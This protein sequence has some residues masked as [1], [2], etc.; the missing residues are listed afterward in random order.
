MIAAQVEAQIPSLRRYARALTGDATAGDDLVQ[1]CMER[2]LSRLH[3]LRPDS[4]LRA[5]L[6]T[7]MRNIWRN[8]LQ[9]RAARPPLHALDDQAEPS[10]AGDQLDRL[11]LRDM[12]AA[13][14]ALP[15]EQREVVLLVALEGLR[16][17]EVA[18]IAGVPIGTVMSR[19]K[20][21]RD[22]LAQL[23]GDSPPLRRVK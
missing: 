14:L 8:E 10:V 6:F 19:L 15:D 18:A 12:Q 21:G 1:D 23:T 2:A 9:R 7:I 17:A 20:R 22:R 16:Y 11:A 5:W 3:L 13:L 4:N